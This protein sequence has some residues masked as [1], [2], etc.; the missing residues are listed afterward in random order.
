M[1][2]KRA[3]TEK[4]KDYDKKYNPTRDAKLVGASFNMKVEEDVE[5]YNKFL[6]LKEHYGLSANMLLKKLIMEKEID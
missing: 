4:D 2:T 6:M 3:R 1:A 5:V